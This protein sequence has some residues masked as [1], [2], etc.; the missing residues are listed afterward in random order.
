MV[1]IPIFNASQTSSKIPGVPTGVANPTA[2][3]VLPYQ[4]MA[5]VG[6]TILDQGVKNY[7]QDLDFKTKKYEIAQNFKTKKHELAKNLQTEKYKI[8]KDREIKEHEIKEKYALE[9]HKETERLKLLWHENRI[10]LERETTVKNALMDT[11]DDIH[12]ASNEAM[13]MQDTSKALDYYDGVINSYR[14]IG[15]NQIDDL[16]AK[17]LF[18]LEYNQKAAAERLTVS[19]GIDKNVLANNLIAFQ[20]EVDLLKNEALHGSNAAIKTNAWHQLFGENSIF[21]KKHNQGMLKVN[22]VPVLPH[23]YKEIIKKEVFETQGDILSKNNPNNFLSLK[24]SGYWN[25]KLSDTKIDDYTD[26]ANRILAAEHSAYLTD[27]RT[28]KTSFNGAV[29]NFIDPGNANYFNDLTEY[30]VLLNNGVSLVQ[31]LNDAGLKNEAQSVLN[32]LKSLESAKLNHNV[33]L[34]LKSKPLNVIRDNLKA[35][36]S[37]NNATSGT[38]DHDQRLIDLE[39]HIQKLITYMES[40]IENNAIGIAESTGTLVPTLNWLEPDI[41]KFAESAQGYNNFVLNNTQK[42]ELPSHQFFRE[43]NLFKFKEVFDTGNKEEILTL[44]RNV[45]LVAGT[46]SNDAFR[47]LGQSSDLF[48]HMG[49]MIALNNGASTQATEMMVNGWIGSRDKDNAA[50]IKKIPGKDSTDFKN[51]IT[52]MFSPAY[53]QTVPETHKQISEATQYIFTDM[54][55][56]DVGLQTLINDEDFNNEAI[57]QALTTSIQYASGMVRKGNTL[58]GG[59]EYFNTTPIIIPQEKANGSLDD[60]PMENIN[61]DAPSLEFLL[62]NY[63]TDTMLQAA[64]ANNTDMPFLRSYNNMPWDFHTNKEITAADLITGDYDSIFLETT[65]YGEY[66]ITRGSPGTPGAEY[67]KNKKQENITL[68][69]NRILPQ[70]LAA[71]QNLP[72]ITVNILGTDVEVQ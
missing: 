60:F 64:T 11:L 59:I 39:P 28:Q 16:L 23:V 45:S 26:Q 46:N 20:D 70:L 35:L 37:L 53:F 52:N 56:S 47:Q 67:Y 30:D 57:Q 38:P 31:T 24:E 41:N 61:G 44:V 34:D 9:Q 18:E 43:E 13:N 10:K 71:H 6:K 72:K 55:L 17:K 32:S 42:Y 7:G 2:A 65:D 58:N 12:R 69:I 62:E 3:A 25:D 4:A 68:N 49:M 19:D 51:A 50:L 63:L 66:Y 48:A 33:I 15:S 8:S 21:D 22:G 36:K 29:T 1:Q 27:L 40:N 14:K 5:N 54:I